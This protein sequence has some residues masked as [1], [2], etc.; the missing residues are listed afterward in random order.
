MSSWTHSYLELIVAC[1]EVGIDMMMK[2][3]QSVL[4]EQKM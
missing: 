1:G 4:Y 3:C 2:L